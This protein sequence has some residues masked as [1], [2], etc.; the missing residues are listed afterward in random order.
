MFNGINKVFIIGSLGSDP[1]KRYMPSGGAI[2]NI[3][4]VT[5]F[6]FKDK[7]TGDFSRKS[8]W[9]RI[10]LYNRLAEIVCDY[11]KKGSK[12]YIE[13]FLRTTRRVSKDNTFNFVTEIVANNIQIF[14][15]DIKGS[16]SNLDTSFD[17]N[18]DNQINFEDDVQ[19]FDNN[20]PF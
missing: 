14:D 10:V 5:S 8:E 1:N 11:L 20:V 3:S 9:H 7:V 18:Y 6:N 16:I 4:V 17:V 15:F 19:T 2:S 12:I 13:G